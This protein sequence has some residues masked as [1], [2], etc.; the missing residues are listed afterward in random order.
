MRFFFVVTFF[1]MTGMTFGQNRTLIDSLKKELNAS[2][3]DKQFGL[4]NSI[5]WEYRFSNPDSTIYFSQKAYD[6]GQR[7]GIK[8]ELA[9]SLNFIGVA[10]NY[11]G[12]RLK[13]F[14]YYQKAIAVA[15]SQND[16]VQMAYSNNNIGRLLFEQGV[17]PKS[18]NY[19]VKALKLFNATS[20][21]S[22]IAYVKQS[23]ANLYRLQQDFKKSENAHLDALSIRIKLKNA[24]YWGVNQKNKI[25]FEDKKEEKKENLA[26]SGQ[27]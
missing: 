2:T 27:I 3:P 14:E 16:S 20:D 10:Y 22:G 21:S 1:L 19:Y 12:D 6:F 23:M 24:Q 11:K 18:F 17:L 4:L 26:K 25:C 7:S 8:S 15:E 9:K 13:S 5:G